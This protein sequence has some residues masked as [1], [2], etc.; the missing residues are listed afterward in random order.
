MTL[1]E[2]VKHPKLLRPA[3]FG[4]GDGMMSIL[5]SILYLLGHSNLIVPVAVFGSLSAAL[6]MAGMEYLSDSSNGLGASAVMGFATALGGVL[7]VIP[8]MFAHGPMAI[9]I[10]VAICLCV[11]VVIGTMRGKQCQKHTMFQEIAGTLV[12]IGLIFG[13]I[14]GLSLLIPGGGG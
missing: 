5:G 6:S 1:P 2:T 8:F 12:L 3:I 13:I 4:M 7:P 9:G 14:L 11:G 10:M